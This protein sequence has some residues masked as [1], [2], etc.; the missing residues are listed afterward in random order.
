MQKDA[1]R[2][3]PTELGK[4]VTGL[5]I[6]SFD[7]IFDVKY[8]ARMEEELDEIEEGQIAW[9]TAIG[10]FYEKFDKDLKHAEEHMT[11]IKRM[12]KPTE[13]MCEKCGKPLVIKWGKHGSFLACTGYPD[14]PSRSAE[15]D[16]EKLQKEIAVRQRRAFNEIELDLKK[17]QNRYPVC[18]A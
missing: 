10:D 2:F 7:D 3:I 5:L 15:T 11:D 17:L 18:S 9:R 12:E 4:V 8:T 1:G 13:L 6:E 14:F 16:L